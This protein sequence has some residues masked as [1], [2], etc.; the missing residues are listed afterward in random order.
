MKVVPEGFLK[1]CPYC[2]NNFLIPKRYGPKW[3]EKKRKYCSIQ[4]KKSAHSGLSFSPSTQ[5]STDRTSWT[6]HPRFKTG[7]WSYRK[8]IKSECEDCGSTKH[9][10]VHHMDEDRNNNDKDNLRTVCSSCHC[11]VY[12]PR[13]FY[14]NQYV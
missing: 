2:N 12:H 14:G 3:A 10:V 9:L 11:N 7:I 8:F 5:F 1:E 4:C 13:K 6:N